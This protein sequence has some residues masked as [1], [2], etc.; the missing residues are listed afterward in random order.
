MSSSDQGNGAFGPVKVVY[1]EG[2]KGLE[3]PRELQI[4]GRCVPVLRV[5]SRERIQ[6]HRTGHRIEVFKLQ[7]P[8]SRVT[9][10]VFQDGRAEIERRHEHGE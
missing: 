4:E 7:L 5:L 1:Y 3:T 10:R 6:D 2:Y 8:H 9:L